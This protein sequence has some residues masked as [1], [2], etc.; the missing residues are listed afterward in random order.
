MQVY[1]AAEVKASV[2]ASISKLVSKK[3]ASLRGLFFMVAICF[4]IFYARPTRLREAC[5]TWESNGCE[6]FLS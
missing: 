4:F 6:K 1:A 2:N 5:Y 3:K